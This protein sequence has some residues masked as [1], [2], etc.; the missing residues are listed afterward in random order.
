[1]DFY[2]FIK[3]NYEIEDDF[4]I[5]P[6]CITFAEQADYL[7]EYTNEV[8]YDLM[9]EI[10]IEELALF[11][12]TGSMM[13]YEG[14]VSNEIK[15]KISIALM[16]I[17]KAIEKFWASVMK[18]FTK[19]PKDLYSPISKEFIKN[20][21]DKSF[22]K[23]H[24]F[25]DKEDVK[26]A[27]NSWKVYEQSVKVFK[28]LMNSTASKEDIIKGKNKI[29][30]ILCST[31]SGLSDCNNIK[32]IKKNLKTKLIGGEV[33]ANKEFLLKNY[34]DLYDYVIAGNGKKA[35]EAAYAKE[36]DA[37][38]KIIDSIDKDFDD[39]FPDVAIQWQGVIVNIINAMHSC[40]ASLADVY[41]K[42]YHEYRNILVKVNKLEKKMVS[43][44]ESTDTR[45]Y[46]NI[47]SFIW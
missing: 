41:N 27:D 44:N 35:V 30:D 40:Y 32:C 36:R 38:H 16:R 23:T 19:D 29:D 5:P 8:F 12:S 42:R 31:I 10:G 26:F 14:V 24:T 28:K 11:E 17:W 25:Y 2:S 45:Q 46:N 6:T 1:M 21:E 37:F 20:I 34:K 9:E 15:V 3:E 4:V 47:E 7:A 18:V 43:S 39:K 33:D 22:G 13:V